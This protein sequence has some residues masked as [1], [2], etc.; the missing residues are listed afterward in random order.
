ML[1]RS[2]FPLVPQPSVRGAASLSDS[3]AKLSKSAD[4][5]S[6]VFNYSES[7]ATKS[8]GALVPP[9]RVEAICSKGKCYAVAKEDGVSKIV[10]TSAPTIG[11]VVPGSVKGAVHGGVK[12]HGSIWFH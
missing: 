7:P 5:P 11:Q 12:V 1:S 6:P 4:K 3:R 2:R 10:L 9:E 8:I